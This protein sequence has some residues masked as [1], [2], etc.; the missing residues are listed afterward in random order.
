M[1][2]TRPHARSPWPP[3]A[4]AGVAVAAV[5]ALLHVARGATDGNP[6]FA[7]DPAVVRVEALPEWMPLEVAEALAADLG[8]ALGDPVPLLDRRALAAWR[9]T[10][11]GVLRASRECRRFRIRVSNY[12]CGRWRPTWG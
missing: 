4:L 12:A 3:V 5:V 9:A 8:S 10:L 11:P 2:A 1:A 7:V 6:R